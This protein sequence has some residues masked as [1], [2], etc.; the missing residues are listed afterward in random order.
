MTEA[1]RRKPYTVILFD[2]IEKAHP[3]VFNI[4][5]QILD[6]GRLTDGQ[7]RVVNF[8]NTVIIM[9]SNVGSRVI[10][11]TDDEKAI[12]E[13]IQKLLK[14]QFKPEFL[15]RIDEIIIFNK[16]KESDIEKIVDIQIK[17]LQERLSE[18][19][20]KASITEKAR[21]ELAKEGFDPSFGVRPLKRLI[22]KK[23]YDIIALKLLKGE[24]KEKSS[25]NIDY[26]GKNNKFIIGEKA[27][28][29]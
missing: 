9:T 28:K 12:K 27:G 11:E 15:N 25:I 18:K 20:I 24:V 21:G 17:E 7:G 23:L 3:D 2:E 14:A 16:L 8:K 29:N 22:Q 1:I 10:Q 5:L 26:D 13:E 6:E 4:L 19:S